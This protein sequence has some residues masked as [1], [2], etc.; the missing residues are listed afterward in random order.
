[1]IFV[2]PPPRRRGKY[3][4]ALPKSGSHTIV[5]PAPLNASR[6]KSWPTRSR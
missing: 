2:F 6:S 3:P 4:A 5:Y 1:M